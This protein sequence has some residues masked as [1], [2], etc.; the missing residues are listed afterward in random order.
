[1]RKVISLLL[2]FCLLGSVLGC[3]LFSLPEPTPSKDTTTWETREQRLEVVRMFGEHVLRYAVSG[4]EYSGEISGQ[5]IGHYSHGLFFGSGYSS[6]SISG[7]FGT[8]ETLVFSFE[9]DLGEIIPGILPLRIFKVMIDDT[10]E[11]PTIEFVFQDSWLNK[12]AES[13]AGLSKASV[14]M[15]NWMISESMVE[16]GRLVGAIVRISQTDLSKETCLPRI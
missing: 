8:E 10:K 2:L 12:K 13:W 14:T 7:D 4:Q 5:S 1:M 15:P 6:G 3:G 9:R 16:E 11:F